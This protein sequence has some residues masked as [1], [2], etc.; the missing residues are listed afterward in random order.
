MSVRGY[1]DGP[2]NSFHHHRSAAL[3]RTRRGGQRVVH[4]SRLWEPVWVQ[5]ARQVDVRSLVAYTI[6]KAR[7][8]SGGGAAALMPAKIKCAIALS[9]ATGAIALAGCWPF[10][11]NQETQQQKF[12]QALN[13]GNG[14]QASQ[15]WLN[16]DANSRADFSHSQGMQ[17]NFSSDEVQKQVMQHYQD[18]MGADDSEE[19]I[20][21]PTPY[22]DLGGLE[23]LPG[24]VGPSGAAPQSVTAPAQ[25]A[26]S[27]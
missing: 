23:S 20:E 22:L 5:F 24:Y 8:V 7:D 12:I 1:S 10:H 4:G 18:K 2:Q 26:P 11:S 25:N 3:R 6:A 21:R 9:I 27:D 19:S 15:I 13:R 16:M 14:A 17:P